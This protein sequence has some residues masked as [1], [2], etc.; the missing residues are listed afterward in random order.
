MALSLPS[1]PAKQMETEK[2]ME[3]RFKTTIDNLVAEWDEKLSKDEDWADKDRSAKIR[4]IF[5]SEIWSQVKDGYDKML[6]DLKAHFKARLEAK[7]IAADLFA[8]VKEVG[9][10]KTTLERREKTKLFASINDVFIEMHDLVGLRIVPHTSEARKEVQ[11]FIDKEFHQLKPTAHISSD[12]KVGEFWDVRFGAYESN[13]H[14]VGINLEYGAYGGSLSSYEGVMFEIQ[15]TSLADMLGNILA[16]PLQ[17]K[18]KHGPLDKR[19]EQTLD[20]LKGTFKFLDVH[21]E[22]FFDAYDAMLEEKAIE[23]ESGSGSGRVMT[24]A[25]KAAALGD[26]GKMR[27]DVAAAVTKALE[28]RMHHLADGVP[29]TPFSAPEYWRQIKKQSNQLKEFQRKFQQQ[30]DRQYLEKL[31]VAKGAA[32]DAQANEHD[33]SC[34][35]DTRVDLLADIHKWIE[36]PNGK[37]IFWLRGMAGTGKST[38]SRTV[39]KKLSTA[40]VPSASFFFKKGEGD[41]GSAAKF[42]T[43]ILA[44]LVRRVPILASHVQSVIENDP[45]IVDKNKKEQFEKLILEPLNKCKVASSPLLAVVVDALDECDREEDAKVLVYLFSRA[46]EVAS[47]R[48]RFFVTSRPELP[49]RLGFK[50]IGDN[51]QNLALHKV[52]K[53]DIKRDIST[54][55]RSELDRIRQDFNKTVPGPG[56]PSDWPPP[57]RFKDLV[58]MAVPLFIFASTAC[59]FIADIH[60]GNPM[61][62]LDKVL[63]YKTKRGRSQLHAT[64]LPILNQLLLKRTNT[65]S[66]K[67]TGEE[68]AQIIAWFRDIVGT[69]VLLAD[70]LPSASLALILG[71]T[72]HDVDSKLCTL[73]SVLDISDDPLVP[74]KLLH[75]SFRDFLVDQENRDANPFWVDAQRTHEQLAG[76]CLKLLSTGDT[77]RRDVCDLRHPGT[78]R[79]ET[80][81]QTINTALPPEVQYACRYWVHHWKES[82]RQ[83]RDGDPVHLFLTDRL[84]YW[85][86]ALGITGRI[87]ESFDMANCLLDMLQPEN[88]TAASALIHELQRFLLAN[89]TVVDA[90]PLQIYYS[91]LVFAPEKSIVR[92]LWRKEFPNCISLLS[93]VDLNWNA[94]QTLDGHSG[95]VRSVAFSPDGQRLASASDDET[96][97]LWDATTGACLQTLKGHSGWV[98]SVAFSPDGQRLASASDDETVKLWDAAT[99][100]RVRDHR[101]QKGEAAAKYRKFDDLKLWYKGRIGALHRIQ[102]AMF[103]RATF[104]GHRG[105]VNSVAFSPDGQRLAS[106]SD[107]KT[108]KLWDAATGACLQTLKGHRIWV[109]SVA[110]SPDGQRLASAS[111]DKTVKLWDAATGACLQTLKGHSSWVRSVAFSPDGQRLASASYDETVKLWDAAT[112]VC[113]TTL[114]GVTSTLSFDKTGSYLHTDFGTKLLHKK[115]AAG[116]ATVQAHLQ[117]QDFEGVGTSANKAWITWNGKR[118]VWLPTEYRG[119]CTAIAGLTIALGCSSGRVLFFQWSGAS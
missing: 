25:A 1:G 10:I 37:C 19:T 84:L 77:L 108:V 23:A 95:S 81:L 80:S 36:D 102:S 29:D 54:F 100:V 6:Q 51:Y 66:D 85:L 20:L 70:P 115:P 53:P 26:L 82:R 73:H 2:D 38:I 78:L 98:R 42:F 33:P 27:A 8:R 15:V 117:H 94:Y 7:D 22:Q 93:P 4:E 48:L 109:N 43:T 9:S 87:L 45:A 106:T 63:E 40:K 118:F 114:D 64:Y 35:P 32:F 75:L 91:A 89:A 28:E 68:E 104:E 76:R 67:R 92:K 103:S 62:Q 60:Y 58:N 111:F 65:G 113:L 18:K 86:E 119:Q 72:Q 3:Q 105:G 24:K 88:S 71:R 90:S 116:P 110:F 49:I 79:S 44:Q 21:L 46:G 41:R 83:I 14:R 34:H 31:P 112:G 30:Q 12:R 52:P 11:D 107:D 50:E 13:N 5:V 96:V 56:L 16:H 99:G 39:A 61:E 47:F 101:Y 74:V 55:L 97:K 69:I 57:A 17:Y 59:R